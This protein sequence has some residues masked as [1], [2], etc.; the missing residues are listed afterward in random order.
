MPGRRLG[1]RPFAHSSGESDA[2]SERGGGQAK[3]ACL[4]SR[5][6]PSL[7][8]S[9]LAL[10][11]RLDPL[12]LGRESLPARGSHGPA[13]IGLPHRQ[14]VAQPVVGQTPLGRADLTLPSLD[15]RVASGAGNLPGNE[16]VGLA[17]RAAGILAD[18]LEDR[19]V[20]CPGGQQTG[21]GEPHGPGA[22]AN[23]GV[24][25]IEDR[26]ELGLGDDRP[27]LGRAGDGEEAS[28][29][30][31]QG[32]AMHADSFPRPGSGHESH[33]GQGRGSEQ[34]RAVSPEQERRWAAPGRRVVER[35]LGE[36]QGRRRRQGD[37][38][39]R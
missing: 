38:G 9:C 35:P 4:E 13:G 23:R 20:E 29:E 34:Q 26:E 8:A 17:D 37:H 7:R 25:L 36:R 24:R 2:G 39:R 32:V 11:E 15:L 19:I 31:D 16:E 33:P 30:A 12:G 14:A 3:P 28:K 1:L 27:V 21:L 10:R 18:R 6:F 5:G 22:L